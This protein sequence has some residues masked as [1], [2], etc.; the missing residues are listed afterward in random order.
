VKNAVWAAFLVQDLNWLQV[1]GK[2]GILREILGKSGKKR[3]S[4]T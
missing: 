1:A 4:P 2:K 3:L